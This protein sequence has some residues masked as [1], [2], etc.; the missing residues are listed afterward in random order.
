MIT[1]ARGATSGALGSRG[2]SRTE[3]RAAPGS[4]PFRSARPEQVDALHDRLFRAY[5]VENLDVY[6]LEVLVRLATE[7]GLDGAA[8]RAA[9]EAGDYAAAR[10]QAWRVA[11]EAGVRGVPTYVADGRGVV[12]AQPVELLEQLIAGESRE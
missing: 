9:L 6:D 2:R 11:M 7:V 1:P 12:G 8:A 3:R 5:Q 4:C 10:Q